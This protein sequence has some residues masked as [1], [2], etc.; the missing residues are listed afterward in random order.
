MRRSSDSPVSISSHSARMA[1]ISS[2]GRLE[3]AE[4]AGVEDVAQGRGHARRL[5]RPW[6]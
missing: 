1:R 3:V 4:V 6:R 5:R 2:I